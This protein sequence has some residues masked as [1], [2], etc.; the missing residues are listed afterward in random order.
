VSSQEGQQGRKVEG[1]KE[2]GIEGV[3]SGGRLCSCCCVTG[4]GGVAGGFGL[5]DEKFT[6]RR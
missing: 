6:T 5:A 3:D 1:R 4:V 2:V